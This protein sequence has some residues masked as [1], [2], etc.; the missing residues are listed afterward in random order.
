VRDDLFKRVKLIEKFHL[1]S[2]GEIIKSCLAMIKYTK[3]KG[4]LQAFINAIRSEVS[5]TFCARRGYVK[6]HIMGAMKGKIL[7]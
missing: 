5:N 7:L 2:N 3:E 1:E 6:R 4:N